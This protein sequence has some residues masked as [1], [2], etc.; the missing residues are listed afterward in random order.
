MFYACNAT[1]LKQRQSA[2]FKCL[3]INGLSII[4]PL[5]FAYQMYDGLRSFFQRFCLLATDSTD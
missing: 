4:W 2:Y 5:F 1:N 3:K